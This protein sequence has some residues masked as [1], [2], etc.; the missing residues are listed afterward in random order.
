MS[1]ISYLVCC[2]SPL[3]SSSLTWISQDCFLHR[4]SVFMFLDRTTLLVYADEF[5]LPRSPRFIWI[6]HTAQHMCQPSHH[7]LLVLWVQLPLLQ[8]L[9]LLSLSFARQV[10]SLSLLLPLCFCLSLSLPPSHLPSNT[11]YYPAISL[12]EKNRIRLLQIVTESGYNQQP[13]PTISSPKEQS[14]GH[15]GRTKAEHGPESASCLLLGAKDARTE[16]ACGSWALGLG[17]GALPTPVRQ[18]YR[19]SND[20]LPSNSRWQQEA[21]EIRT[22]R[23]QF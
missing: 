4:V 8:C 22:P 23:M 19:T 3:S 21:P 6:I 10:F 20:W 12:S 7:Q 14:L 13:H 5:V 16:P 11:A 2:L 1:W 17:E 18:A 15:W 9:P